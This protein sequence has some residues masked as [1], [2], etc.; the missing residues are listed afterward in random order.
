[1]KWVFTRD[2]RWRAEHGGRRAFVR[3][4]PTGFVSIVRLWY[5]AGRWR[6]WWQGTSVTGDPLNNVT[7]AK[8]HCE[9]WLLNGFSPAETPPRTTSPVADGESAA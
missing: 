6:A 5:R 8:K 4:S 7:A 9:P 1:M 3:R 2:R